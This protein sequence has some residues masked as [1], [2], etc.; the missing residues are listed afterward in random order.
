[1]PAMHL[2][3][4]LLPEPLRP[5]MP[6]NSPAATSKETPLRAGKV[7]CSERRIGCSARSLSVWTRSLGCWNVF[8]TPSTTTAGPGPGTKMT[9]ADG[10]RGEPEP[11]VA[12]A[13]G[14]RDRDGVRPLVQRE[15]R[16]VVGAL[17]HAEDDAVRGGPGHEPV[18]AA[19]V[20]ADLALER[21]VEHGA[22]L[23]EAGH[24]DALDAHDHGA[25]AVGRGGHRRGHAELRV[26][27]GERA[28]RAAAG[29]GA[30]EQEPAPERPAAGAEA[31]EDGAHRLG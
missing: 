2:S 15:R 10:H 23:L 31:A 3:S 26:D 17:R 4:V 16:G 20:E 8:E 9:L 6:K 25:R 5:T 7:S 28:L 27:R 1:M 18:R 11:Q 12:P 19:A 29:R 13:A 14:L 22:D 21:A 24:A 30:L